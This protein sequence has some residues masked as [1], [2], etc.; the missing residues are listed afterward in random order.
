[1]LLWLGAGKGSSSS[2]KS[3]L[4]ARISEKPGDKADREQGGEQGLPF[5]GGGDGEELP[6]LTRQ[7]EE[8]RGC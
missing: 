2:S 1:V 4:Y 8:V 7:Q 6:T 3:R 5:L